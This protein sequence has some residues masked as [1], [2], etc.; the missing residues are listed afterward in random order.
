MVKFN[1][2]KNN[3]INLNF[4]I[5]KRE[6]GDDAVLSVCFLENKLFLKNL[7]YIKYLFFLIFSCNFKWV[8][9]RFLNFPYLTYCEIELFFKKN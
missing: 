2:H 9:K 4:I 7:F 5:F 3:T 8:E 1:H 6:K